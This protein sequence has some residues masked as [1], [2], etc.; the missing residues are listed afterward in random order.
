VDHGIVDEH[1][2][3]KMIGSTN[4]GLIV[5]SDF[6]SQKIRQRKKSTSVISAC[7]SEAPVTTG[8]SGREMNTNQPLNYSTN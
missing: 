2:N 1:M 4:K 5:L 3:F 8:T 7:S 6:S